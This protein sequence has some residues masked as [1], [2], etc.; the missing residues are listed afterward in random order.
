VGE[1]AKLGVGVLGVALIAAFIGVDVSGLP[2]D[3]SN[4]LLL[5]GLDYA[6]L[7]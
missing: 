6:W 2:V 4:A 7:I 1:Y 3:A 5:A